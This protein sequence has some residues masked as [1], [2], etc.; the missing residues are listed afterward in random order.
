V[1]SCAHAPPPGVPRGG[2]GAALWPGDGAAV[3]PGELK[4]PSV[5]MKNAYKT[6]VGESPARRA[7]AAQPAP[8]EPPPPR[9]LLLA[10]P[11]PPLD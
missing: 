10:Q 8:L 1:K 2:C 11:P 9:P 6:L 3:Q 5:Q 7:R 4:D